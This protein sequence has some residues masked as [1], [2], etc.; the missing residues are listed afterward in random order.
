MTVL[1]CLSSCFPFGRAYASRAFNL[2][3]ML[4]DS[5][6][7]IIVFCDFLS[8]ELENYFKTDIYNYEG[9]TI[10][11]A[12]NNDRRDNTLIGRLRRQMGVSRKLD[13]FLDSRNIDL[14]ICSSAPERFASIFKV[15]KKHRIPLVLEICEWFDFY[16]WKFGRFD[17]RHWMADI[18]WKKYYPRVNGAIVISELLENEFSKFGVSTIRIPTVLDIQK[19]LYNVSREREFLKLLFAG[20]ISTGKDRLCEVITSLC[21][22]FSNRKVI[23]DIYGP[24]LNDIEQQLKN[25]EYLL[26]NENIIIHGY[27]PQYEINEACCN[28]DFGLILRPCRRSSDAGFPT[29]LGEYF[30]AGTPVIANR[31]GDIAN[32]LFNGQNGFLLEDIDPKSISNLIN[33]LMKMTDNQLDEMRIK[34]R[35]TAALYFDYRVY[36]DKLNE[37]L[38]EILDIAIK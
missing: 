31:T 5:G 14:V 30:A 11:P 3:K 38:I 4:R 2:C 32:Y 36:Q 27:R 22:E 8:P 29:K 26:N 18:C 12:F 33:L 16:S 1:Y 10:F 23:L 17:P 9:I 34:A 24:T 6:N 7:T 28:A 35:E 37:F 19:Q 21:S 20:D 13:C 15:V 25:R